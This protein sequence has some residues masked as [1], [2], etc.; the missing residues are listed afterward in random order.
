MLEP[1]GAEEP[2]AL[3]LGSINKV[4]LSKSLAQTRRV[5]NTAQATKEPVDT[6]VLLRR[7]DVVDDANPLPT[8]ERWSR[9]RTVLLRRLSGV[10][11]DNP[12]PTEENRGQGRVVRTW[13]PRPALNDRILWL[14]TIFD[15]FY[16]FCLRS[17]LLREPKF[18]VVSRMQFSMPRILPPSSKVTTDKYFLS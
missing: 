1:K 17:P 18:L 11:V 4:T 8:G 7:L 13:Q 16:M 6:T 5:L 14:K 12:L 15:G 9:K 10:D 3:P 2:K